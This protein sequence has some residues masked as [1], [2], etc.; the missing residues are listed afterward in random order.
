MALPGMQDERFVTMSLGTEGSSTIPNY[1]QEHYKSLQLGPA[2]G[3]PTNMVR[4]IEGAQPAPLYKYTNKP[5]YYDPHDIR[6][7]KS[8]KL[9]RDTNSIDYTL[10]LDDIEG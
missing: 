10:K 9:I 1:R 2:A 6:G 8:N 5:S 3:R 4:D 7:T